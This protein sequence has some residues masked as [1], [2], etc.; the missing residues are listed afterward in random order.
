MA[1]AI[2]SVPLVGPLAFLVVG[3]F[4]LLVFVLPGIVVAYA[5]Y[6]LMHR[7]RISGGNPS[8]S[9]QEGRERPLG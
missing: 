6:R 5:G 8:Y 3:W 2:A 9:N 7:K 1:L 4:P